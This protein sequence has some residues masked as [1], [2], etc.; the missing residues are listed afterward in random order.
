MSSFNRRGIL[1]VSIN[2][3]SAITQ[4]IKS[5]NITSNDFKG[6]LELAFYSSGYS[7]AFWDA[8]H[9]PLESQ[10]MG[11]YHSYEVGT[12]PKGSS[13]VINVTQS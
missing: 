9:T 5:E 3:E 1:I 13:G 12:I 7:V 2:V 4:I 10:V 6:K 8:S 11:T